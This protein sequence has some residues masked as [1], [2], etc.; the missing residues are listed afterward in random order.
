MNMML[1]ELDNVAR[2]IPTGAGGYIF[3]VIYHIN[4]DLLIAT[5]EEKIG[6]VRH[7][8]GAGKIRSLADWLNEMRQTFGAE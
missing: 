5:Q 4:P 1:L 7:W 8:I 6:A 2:A 3:H